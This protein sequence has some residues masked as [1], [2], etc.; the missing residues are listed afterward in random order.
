MNRDLDVRHVLPAVQV[1]TLVTNR[2]GDRPDIAHGSRYIAE[3]IAGARHLELRGEDH[4]MF[5]SRK[6]L[7]PEI[8][9]F[10]TEA[11]GSS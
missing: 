10:F 9:R 11:L 8:Q 3:K 1:P 4:S 6:Q 5:V 2:T 7:L